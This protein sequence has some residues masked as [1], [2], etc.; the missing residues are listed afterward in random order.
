MLLRLRFGKAGEEQQGKS[1]RSA[2][3]MASTTSEATPHFGI[4]GTSHYPPRR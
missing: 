1:V 2:H 3:T 4:S